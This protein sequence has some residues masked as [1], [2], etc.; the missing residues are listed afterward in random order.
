MRPL[1]VRP[2]VAVVIHPVARLRGPGVNGRVSIVAIRHLGRGVR[3]GRH[4]Q[5]LKGPTKPPTVTVRIQ[6][7][8]R[9]TLRPGLVRLAVAVV[10]AAIACLR[11]PRVYEGVRVVAVRP[12]RGEAVC[13]RRTAQAPGVARP[14]DSVPVLVCVVGRAPRRALLVRLAVAV[15]VRGVARLDHCTR[16]GADHLAA[17]APEHPR[18]RTILVRQGAGTLIRQVVGLAVTVVV[19]AIARLRR[20][21]RGAARGQTLL[22]APAHPPAGPVFVRYKTIRLVPRLDEIGRA[23]ADPRL[24]QAL[25]GLAPV[26]GF[27]L[28]AGIPCGTRARLRAVLP[29][30]RPLPV[31][32]P[33][34]QV[35]RE[36][37]G[38]AAILRQPARAAQTLHLRQAHEHDVADQIRD[39]LAREARR[40]HALDAVRGAH[41][42]SVRPLHAEPRR[43]VR[44]R[45]ARFESARVGLVRARVPPGPHVLGARDLDV[46]S[47]VVAHVRD[48]DPEVARGRSARR[49][50]SAPTE[51]RDRAD[52]EPRRG[53]HLSSHPH[54][55]YSSYP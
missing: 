32:E 54:G 31:P 41:Q 22:G 11:R 14:R 6:E 2:A 15:V 7:I 25:P 17:H 43:A 23:L 18:T 12:G 45:R 13:P 8:R 35:L 55:S 21:G 27:D 51:P 26:R 48:P 53:R 47:H 46:G 5:A 3:C 9:T 38:R 16:P 30:E 34:A 4:A 49:A 42:G 50:A 29:A 44:A 28:P 36:H 19:E 37:A 10:V 24:G 39:L 33:D 1:S 40:A 52:H 20:R